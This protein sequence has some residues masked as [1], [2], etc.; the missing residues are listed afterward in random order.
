APGHLGGHPLAPGHLGGHPHT[1]A[2]FK[3]N[4]DRSPA[5]G[6]GS[7]LDGLPVA[8]QR[9]AGGDQ[10]AEAGVGHQ[11]EG[12]VEGPYPPASVIPG[13]TPGP[14]GIPGDTPGPP[15]IPGDTPGP[16]AILAPVGIGADEF[17]L[18]LPQGSE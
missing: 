3:H 11:I 12:E 18:P 8:L 5:P 17:D 6:G 15:G 9:I 14:P 16:P 10:P 2:W 4:L 13:D 7:V 1:S